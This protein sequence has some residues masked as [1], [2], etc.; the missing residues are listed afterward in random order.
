MFLGFLA[1]EANKQTNKQINK[2][3]FGVTVSERMSKF[4]KM[5][6]EVNPSEDKLIIIK[7]ECWTFSFKG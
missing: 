4:R 6:I 2:C 3:Y 7:Q 5:T 1:C